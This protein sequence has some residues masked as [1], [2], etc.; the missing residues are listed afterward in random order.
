M[1]LSVYVSSKQ[2][3]SRITWRNFKAKALFTVQYYEHLL[4]I[5]LHW[6]IYIGNCPVHAPLR[7]Q[8]LSFWHTKFSKRN[9]LRSPHPPT[10]STPPTGIP[11]SATEFN[12]QLVCDNSYRK[13][14][15]DSFKLHIL[16][17]MWITGQ[18]GSIECVD[19]NTILWHAKLW[20]LAGNKAR[21]AGCTGWCRGKDVGMFNVFN[22]DNFCWNVKGFYNVCW[23]TNLKKF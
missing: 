10:R 12:I 8:I 6:R 9:R 21:I 13:S 1:T 2:S 5:L 17:C 4:W 11:G 20:F 22:K 15:Q 16:T 18:I 23:L 14:I 3:C 19:T 7:V